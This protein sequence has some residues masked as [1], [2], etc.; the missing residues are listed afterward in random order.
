MSVNGTKV[1][2]GEL[3][4]TRRAIGPNGCKGKG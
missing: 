3:A 4:K 1:T 2:L